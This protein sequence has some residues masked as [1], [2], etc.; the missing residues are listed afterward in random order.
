MF[1]AAPVGPSIVLDANNILADAATA[2][3]VHICRHAHA[4]TC[5]LARGIPARWYQKKP[6]CLIKAD[7]LRLACVAVKVL[8]VARLWN[9]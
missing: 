2:S 9:T 1:G 6:P 8:E 3:S 7:I 4:W 5:G